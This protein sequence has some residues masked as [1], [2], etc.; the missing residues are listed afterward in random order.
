M[1]SNKNIITILLFFL[2]TFGVQAQLRFIR[3]T[4]SAVETGT[5]EGV[6]IT[7]PTSDVSAF[8]DANGKYTAVVQSTAEFLIFHKAGYITQKLAIPYSSDILDVQLNLDL[9]NLEQERNLPLNRV[10]LESQA[11]THQSR[12]EGTQISTL[13]DRS[14]L[15][16][17]EGKVSGSWV[18]SSGGAS[19]ASQRVQLRGIQSFMSNSQPLIVVDGIPIDNTSSYGLASGLALTDFGSRINDLVPENIQS[20]EVI[21]GSTGAVMYGSRAANGV[22]I[23]KTHPGAVKRGMTRSDQ[24]QFQTSYSFENVLRQPASQD[25]FGQ[26]NQGQSA[27]SSDQSWG[28]AFTGLVTPWGQKIGGTQLE[29]P[30]SAVEDNFS[31]AFKTG[32]TVNN[33]ISFRTGGEKSGLF[34]SIADLRNQGVVE[35]MD[36]ART[37]LQTNAYAMPS[38]NLSLDFRGN[39]T[40]SST[41][42]LSMG[43]GNTFMEAMLH[44]PT[45]I[46]VSQLKDVGSVYNAPAGFYNSAALNPWYILDNN[47]NTNHTD[48]LLTSV[49]AKYHIKKVADLVCR[50][51]S[52]IWWDSRSGHQNLLQGIVGQNANV[53]QISGYYYQEKFQNQSNTLDVFAKRDFTISSG[54]SLNVLLGYGYFDQTKSAFSGMANGLKMPGVYSF[55]NGTGVVNIFENS[56]NTRMH[57]LYSSGLLKYKDKANIGLTARNDRSN[58]WNDSFQ[59]AWNAG[60]DAAL[61]IHNWVKLPKWIPF[62]KARGAVART[63]QMPDFRQISGTWSP[64]FVK[65]QVQDSAFSGPFGNVGRVSIPHDLK[66]EVTFQ[67][68]LGLDVNLLSD[69]RLGM[70]FTYYQSSSTGL[71]CLQPI[72][73]S[74]GFDS[75]AINSGTME[76][77]GIQIDM[78]GTPVYKNGIRWDLGGN[79]FA[80][81]NQVK[82]TTES[83]QAMILGSVGNNNF[84]A[85]PGNSYGQFITSDFLYSADG[86]VIVDANTGK[87]VVNP[88]ATQGTFMP[89]YLFSINSTL[90]YKNLSLYI[91]LDHKDGGKAY[92]RAAELT[93]ANGSASNTLNINGTGN[94]RID[95]VIL[96]SV[97]LGGDGLYHENTKAISVQDYWNSGIGALSI[98]NA[99]YTK[100]R[101]VS[102]RYTLPSS[103]AEQLHVQG[104]VLGVTGRNLL[105]FTPKTNSFIDPESNAYGNS[106]LQGFA[107]GSISGLRSITLSLKIIL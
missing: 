72:A 89:S 15:G 34:L 60:T 35:G 74:T 37:S 81:A 68:E 58:I 6:E 7:S 64:A 55:A 107:I 30:Y 82:R 96:N 4:V 98:L 39:F 91:Q 28:P 32:H 57:S 5:L 95:E 77:K 1:K 102:I 36:Y 56:M 76:N 86:K 33:F 101:E 46:S 42:A 84:A 83:G 92:S 65:N 105:L 75:K 11:A 106:N 48:N 2:T 49:T 50:A 14:L 51:G 62:L 22:I 16:N 97:Y 53:A 45:D 78:R 52:N 85:V 100:L 41:N 9:F 88:Y 24:I 26:G 18:S 44:T 63:Q 79:F 13:S 67:W 27:L 38:K 80:N 17:L 71:V 29:K 87:P 94:E 40:Q 54:W 8:S 25:K 93:Q 43:G 69:S 19:G 20:V 10:A 23:I 12:L 104:A 73:D 3:G 70:G 21:S 90:H 99:S 66:P 47:K 31:K 61:F 103:I 59:G